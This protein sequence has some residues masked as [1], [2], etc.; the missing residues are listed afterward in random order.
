MA[1]TQMEAADALFTL[2]KTTWDANAGGAPLYYENEDFERPAIPGVFGRA[3]IRHSVG[4]RITLG[5]STGKIFRRFG[6]LYVQV[7]T[8]QDT[9]Q[10]DIRVLTDSLAHAFEDVPASFGVRIRD[11]S[12]NELG[13]DGTYFQVNVVADFSYDRWS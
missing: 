5:G 12:I 9:G 1:E 2:V 4:T 10:Y 3:T 6:Q 8:P 13:N 11:V 7:F